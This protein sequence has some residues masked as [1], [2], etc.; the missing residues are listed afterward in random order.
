MPIIV[1]RDEARR[2]VDAGAHL[3]EVLPEHEY[4]EEHLPGALHLP[5]K[6]LDAA[7][8]R[9]LLD[10]ARPVVVYCWDALCDMSPRAAW[11]LERIGF[12]PVYDYAAG[13]VDWMG[14]GLPTVRADTSERR[15]IDATDRDPPT[16]RPDDRLA[17]IAALKERSVVVANE[18]G[19]V[20]GRVSPGRVDVADSTPVEEV[21]AGR[22]GYGAGSR[23][24]ASPRTPR[25][26]PR[27]H[28]PPQCQRGHR[29][30]TPRRTARHPGA[31]LEPTLVAG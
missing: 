8:A 31:R 10:V 14:A 19:I 11:R 21:D 29:D 24:R 2:L 17:D 25:P 7:N 26:T 15:A 5:L 4:T 3:V 30:H 9:A 20:L 16:C 1:D 27:A 28:D 23:N 13:K 18:H 6:R 22:G 12:G